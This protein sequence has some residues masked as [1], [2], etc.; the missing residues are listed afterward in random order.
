MSAHLSDEGAATAETA[1]N[2]LLTILNTR[3]TMQGNTE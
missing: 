1:G 2:V 3:A